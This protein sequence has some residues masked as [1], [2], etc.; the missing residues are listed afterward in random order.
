VFY[1][2]LTDDR[3]RQWFYNRLR[4]CVR[5]NFKENFDVS[6][7]TLPTECNVV[8]FKIHISKVFVQGIGHN[9]K[10][11]QIKN[12]AMFCSCNMNV[13]KSPCPTHIVMYKYHWM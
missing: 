2:R 7:D 5:E 10:F 1:D 8:S 11:F 12:S 9:L 3:D 6:L 4:D 13:L